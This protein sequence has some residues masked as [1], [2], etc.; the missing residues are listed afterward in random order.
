MTHCGHK[1]PGLSTCLELA[2]R[3]HRCHLHGGGPATPAPTAPQSLTPTA[4][5]GVIGLEVHVHLLANLVGE[6]FDARLAAPE[7]NRTKP[8]K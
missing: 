6:I 4:S 2:R 1:E 5:K 8:P 7:T 3:G